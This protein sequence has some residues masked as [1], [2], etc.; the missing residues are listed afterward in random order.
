MY[1]IIG[2]LFLRDYTK[3]CYQVNKLP[4][5]GSIWKF[6][7]ISFICGGISTAI[8]LISTIWAFLEAFSKKD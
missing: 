3:K 1:S 8:I 4:F 5:D 7:L 6:F 2:F